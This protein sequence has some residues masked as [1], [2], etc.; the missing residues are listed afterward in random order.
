MDTI[1]KVKEQMEAKGMKFDTPWLHLGEKLEGG[2]VR[3]T[4]KHIVSI[5]EEPK[6]TKDNDPITGKERQ[7]LLFRVLENE[8]EK[9]WSFPIYGKDG[10]PHYLISRMEDIE[11]GEV[12]SLEI[13]KK[14]LKNYIEVGRITDGSS[15]NDT[16]G[17]EPVEDI[18][19]EEN[20]LD[21][22]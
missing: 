20:S 13:K 19:L 17:V 8:T 21:D 16:H 18:S 9:K 22:L 12:F 10:Q 7:I 15:P 11:V 3:S 1:K 2:G 14:G 5:I 4:G 6:V